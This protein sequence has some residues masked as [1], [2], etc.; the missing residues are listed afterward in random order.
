MNRIASRVARL[1]QRATRS[2]ACRPPPACKECGNPIGWL[3]RVLLIRED[4]KEPN[5]L[6][7][8]CGYPLR[9]TDPVP[10][11]Q[12]TKIIILGKD[13]NDAPSATDTPSA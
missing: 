5:P 11:G 4:L 7:A 1:E 2:I 10:P 6:C 9:G 13:E 8:S 3:P 12:H